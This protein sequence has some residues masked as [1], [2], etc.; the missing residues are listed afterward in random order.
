VAAESLR[1]LLEHPRNHFTSPLEARESI[2]RTREETREKLKSSIAM[3]STDTE[4]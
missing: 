3:Q 1:G 2:G 4:A